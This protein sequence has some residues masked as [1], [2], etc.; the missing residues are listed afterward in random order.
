ME[1]NARSA[2][3]EIDVRRGDAGHS[4]Q[5]LLHR[6]DAGGAGH[7]LDAELHL[8]LG[9]LIAGAFDSRHDRS[10]IRGAGEGDVG[11]AGGEIDIDALD[12]GNRGD[13]LLDMTD[14]GAAVHAFD[15]NDQLR[16]SDGLGAPR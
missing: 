11:A 16:L 8:V 13:R 7:P 1:G 6:R 10:G 14:A 2:G 9:H 3:G 15:R 12:A 5:R 4:A